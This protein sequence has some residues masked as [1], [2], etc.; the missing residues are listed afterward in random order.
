MN[1]FRKKI[2]KDVLIRAMRKVSIS[3][4]RSHHWFYTFLFALV[5]LYS[6]Y[7]WYIHGFDIYSEKDSVKQ[8]LLQKEQRQFNID[9]FDVVLEKVQQRKTDF[10]RGIQVERDIFQ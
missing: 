2:S 6:A 4:S 1:D 10:Y 9:T 7:E 5:A 3:W 8:E